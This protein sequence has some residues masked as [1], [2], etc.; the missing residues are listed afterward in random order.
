MLVRQRL[1]NQY[2]SNA[3]FGSMTVNAAA[4]FSD[5]RRLGS[6]MAVERQTEQRKEEQKPNDSQGCVLC[7]AVRED[8]AS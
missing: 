1:M 3:D 5:P 7:S 2:R 6:R 4:F 8:H